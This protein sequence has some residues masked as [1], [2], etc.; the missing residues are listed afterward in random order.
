MRTKFPILNLANGDWKANMFAT[1]RY[2]N[3]NRH[4]RVTG[5]LKRK[6]PSLR[7][8]GVGEPNDGHQSKKKQKKKA[9]K[10]IDISDDEDGATAASHSSTSHTAHSRSTAPRQKP[11]SHSSTSM[12]IMS[13]KHKP[14][15]RPRPRPQH[16]DNADATP[17]ASSDSGDIPAAPLSTNK[18]NTLPPVSITA[19]ASVASACAIDAPTSS[20]QPCAN[21]SAPSPTPAGVA[22]GTTATTIGLGTN[23]GS[24]GPCTSSSSSTPNDSTT[25]LSPTLAQDVQP[26][27]AT[28]NTDPP[29]T[30]ETPTTTSPQP[31]SSA[32]SGVN[33]SGTLALFNDLR[34]PEPVQQV[35]LQTTLMNTTTATTAVSEARK[36]GKIM[37]PQANSVT[38]RNLFALDHMQQHPM[39]TVTEFGRLWKDLDKDTRDKY[40][41]MSKEKNIEKKKAQKLPK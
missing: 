4:H 34:I 28:T 40:E 35:P 33:N 23:S 25:P 19:A 21:A 32:L 8:S 6:Y 27:T 20:V 38:A 17:A 39:T 9:A 10:V 29:A 41:A 13:G 1:T 18:Q 15:P 12:E 2:P 16:R 7:S 31:P 22:A 37:V 3:W 11:P 30:T 24:V 36:K 14:R 26:P 5:H